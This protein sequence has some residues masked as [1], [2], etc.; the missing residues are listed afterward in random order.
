ME[1]VAE[2]NHS[3]SSQE[4]LDNKNNT[5]KSQNF[6]LFTSHDLV[7]ISLPTKS[8]PESKSLIEENNACVFCCLDYL[9]EK[10]DWS[11]YNG[12]LDYQDVKEKR[13]GDCLKSLIET[14]YN[15]GNKREMDKLAANPILYEYRQKPKICDTHREKLDNKTKE[16]SFAEAYEYVVSF[17]LTKLNYII[18]KIDHQRINKLPPLASKYNENG[19]LIYPQLEND[20]TDGIFQDFVETVLKINMS[21]LLSKLD[22]VCRN[23]ALKRVL[24]S[25]QNNNEDN[26]ISTYI[27]FIH[28]VVTIFVETFFKIE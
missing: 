13:L 2:L 11:L 8:Y 22:A 21:K 23:T 9:C 15:Y 12:R 20:Q 4:L 6:F 3:K 1:N 10:K 24:N 7:N 19:E 16:K 26:K 25:L 14:K 17:Y 28:S 18:Q 27:N 5:E